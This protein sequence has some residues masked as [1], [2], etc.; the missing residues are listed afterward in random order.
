[1][2][3]A[4]YESN[5]FNLTHSHVWSPHSSWSHYSNI[6]V[7]NIQIFQVVKNSN[8]SGCQKL[9]YFWL[10]KTH[11]CNS[12]CPKFKFFWL[13]KKSN[14]S[15][16]QNW[17]DNLHISCFFSSPTTVRETTSSRVCPLF[18]VVLQWS[19]NGPRRSFLLHRIYDLPFNILISCHPEEEL[20]SVFFKII[21]GSSCPINE[22]TS[23]RLPP[24]RSSNWP[25]KA[26]LA[27]CFWNLSNVI[28][29]KY[30]FLK[31]ILIRTAH[32]IC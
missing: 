10:S 6:L 24:L 31:W 28:V 3:E 22:T 2:I 27:K 25:Q 7:V 16:C 21:G 8:I 5:V 32:Q 12:V 26:R 17:K 13:S 29:L 15:G 18:L 14:I 20:V 1:M 23:R 11:T 19:L 30:I 9:K 4:C